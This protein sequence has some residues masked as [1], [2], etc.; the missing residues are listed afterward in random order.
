MDDLHW[1]CFARPT[2][3]AQR[4]IHRQLQESDRSA[5]QALGVLVLTLAI[6]FGLV[7]CS[8]GRPQTPPQQTPLISVALAQLP[9]T[10]MTTGTSTQVSANVTDDPAGAGVDWIVTCGSTTAICGSISPAHTASGDTTTF[11]A[12]TA[13]PATAAVSINA[14]SSTDHSKS[15][16]YAVTVASTV[17]SVTITQLPPTTSP[18]GSHI[19]VSAT[20][21]GDPANLGVDWKASC[22]GVDC[23]PPGLHS[24]SGVP[25]TFV[26]PSIYQIP[27]IVGTTVKLTAY[28]TADHSCSNRV[29]PPPGVAPPFCSAAASFQVASQVL[30]QITQTPPNTMFT[31]AT[32]TVIATVQN[33][34]TNAGADWSVSCATAP[35]GTI[36]PS[37]TASGAPAVFTAPPVVPGDAQNPS[38]VVVITAQ[39]SASASTSIQTG[40]T[41]AAPI[42][43]QLAQN[44]P[45]GTI[46]QGRTASLIAA[47][48]NDSANAGVDWSVE[49]SSPGSCGSFSPAH[50][51]SGATTVYT[52]PPVIPTGGTVTITAAST[53]DPTQTASQTVTVTATPPAN[54]LL[55][56]QFVMLLSSNQSQNGAYVIG[57]VISGDGNGTITNATFDLVDASGNSGQA[58]TSPAPSTYTIGPNG[59]GQIQLL[60]NTFLLNRSFGVTGAA[61]ACG[62]TPNCGSLTL[63][64]VF[65]TPQHAILS[66][67][68]GFGPLTREPTL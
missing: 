64:V 2:S 34:P 62:S 38:P 66:E 21:A 13:V 50:T 61:S 9:P 24:A 18:A 26:V 63:S 1:D 23:T 31:N 68:D 15:A 32:A 33:D 17:T 7:G 10:T 11:T 3:L 57:G 51:A 22:G 46:V 54:S 58:L 47:V 45:N 20:V 16:T 60:I 41:I 55:S 67:S 56:G 29:P 30:I 14:L 37:H 44:V 65:V 42:S 5:R 39:S 28:A 6:S 27:T 53:T 52:A 19:V 35:C 49:C 4:Q 40:V 25:V 12:P 43:L 36:V 48:S 8:T 59:Q